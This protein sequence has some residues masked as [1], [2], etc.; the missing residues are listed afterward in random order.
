M[1]GL[2]ATVRGDRRDGRHDPLVRSRRLLRSVP[3]EA[4]R[5]DAEEARETEHLVTLALAEA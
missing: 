1:V 3:G 5:I 4:D 2:L